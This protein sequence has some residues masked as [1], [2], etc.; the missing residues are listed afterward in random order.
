VWAGIAAVNVVLGIVYYLRWAALLVAAPVGTPPSWRVRPA[1]GVALGATAA[2]CVLFSLL[3][4]IVAGL[5]PG[6]LA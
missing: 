1:E 2:A 3:P 4:Q 5:L 6:P